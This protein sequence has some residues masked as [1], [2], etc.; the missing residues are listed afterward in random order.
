VIAANR[1]LWTPAMADVGGWP[2][3]LRPLTQ[4]APRTSLTHPPTER[5]GTGAR[6]WRMSG[7][8]AASIG[9]VTLAVVAAATPRG[10]VR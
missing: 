3:R 10:A 9:L 2:V 6:A 8:A 5:S 4:A 1:L 7:S